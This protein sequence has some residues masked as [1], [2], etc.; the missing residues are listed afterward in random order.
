MSEGG[1]LTAAEDEDVAEAVATA[2]RGAGIIVHENFGAIDSFEKT[3]AGVRMN[4]SKNGKRGG[5]EAALAVAAAGWVA[6][7]SGLDLAVSAAKSVSTN[8]GAEL[9][10]LR[11]SGYRVSSTIDCPA[12][13]T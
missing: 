2:F 7:T 1:K 5:A 12:S 3:L 8:E 4:L 10:F 6:N 13:S 9:R 11:L